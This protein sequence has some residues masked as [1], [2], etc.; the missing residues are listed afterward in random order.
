MKRATPGRRLEPAGAGVRV[1]RAAITA[2]AM[3]CVLD[4]GFANPASAAGCA[5]AAKAADD[6]EQTVVRYEVVVD[7]PGALRT[8]IENN[9]DLKLYGGLD[10][11]SGCID[12]DRL[13]RLF[14]D[15]KDEVARLVAAQGY[16]T[17]TVD[18]T[19]A[20]EGDRW[21][22]RYRVTP[23][24]LTHVGSVDLS[25]VGPVERA[26]AG[27][28][29]DL[30]ALRDGWSLHTGDVFAQ[31]EWEGDKRKLLQGL[32][33]QTYPF[34]T[35]TRSE[36]AVDVKSATAKLTV[37][38]ASGPAVRFGP[39]Q[40]D[41][42]QRYPPETIRNVDPVTIG[43]LYS[44][45]KLFDFQQKL[46]SS[47]Y[48]SRVEVS[49]NADADPGSDPRSPFVAKKAEAPDAS[50]AGPDGTSTPSNR[51]ADGTAA[52]AAKVPVDAAPPSPLPPEVTLPVRVFVAENKAHTVS[53]G[54]G[55]S[56]NAGPHAS[57]SYNVIDF[58]GG[59][60]Q[61]RTTLAFDQ[62]DQTLAA[63]LLFPTAANGDRYSIASAISR[64]NVQNELTRGAS[65]SGKRAWGPE[66][67][68]QFTSIDAIFERRSID[69]LPN[70]TAATLGG[71]YGI[72]LRRTDNLLTPT[73]GYLAVAQVGGGVRL[74]NGLPF[75]RLYGKAIRFLPVT[76]TNTL[77]VRGEVGTVFA[78]D[79]LSLPSVLLFR[80]GGQGSV[81]GYGYQSL[82]VPVGDAII[83]GRYVATGTL[84]VDHWLAPRF[85]QWGIAGFVDAGN[86]GNRLS[87]LSP[88]VGYGVGARWRSPVGTLD[89]DVA[90][91][92]DNG[93]TRIHFALGVSF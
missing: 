59:A 31:A 15:G 9:L 47:G 30:Q 92:I 60:E 24:A 55:V 84:E 11:N 56:S 72:S 93:T 10:G 58:L 40:I 1:A 66:D 69:Q 82:G 45:Q 33:L 48:F 29:P 34:A 90:H 32:L 17:P 89:L 14:N 5:T 22:A 70:T 2:A 36:A 62:L 81:R 41:G 54:V 68:E 76:E 43:E 78:H 23:N 3:C 83:G 67:T 87:D 61:L 49:I 46:S 50:V 13:H 51:P 73:T 38:I 71:T 52:D 37:V 19:L 65:L 86:A 18:A 44:Q 16:Y 75:A 28:L 4:L 27:Q 64:T 26:P 77:L 20:E 74:T 85:P 57:A 53:L 80:A 88:V 12:E 39:L 42:L 8:L 7:A 25:F 79:P 21:I 91:G 35:L 63:D 6:V